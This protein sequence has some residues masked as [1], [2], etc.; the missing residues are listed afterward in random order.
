MLQFLRIRNLALLEAADLEFASGLVAVTGETGAGKSVLLGALSLLS[1]ARADKSLIRAGADTCTIEAGLW[2]AHPQEV[3]AAL[4]RLGLPLCEDGQLLLRRSFSRTRMGQIA[5]NGSLTTLANLQE[6]GEVW[7]D[8]HGPGEPQKLFQEKWQLSLLDA[9]ARL[10]P[11]LSAYRQA[12][13]R[14]QSL[15]R[16]AA[17]LRTQERLDDDAVE[18]L[19]RQIDAIDRAQLSEESIQILERDFTRFSRA[20]EIQE[21]ARRLEYALSGEEG[22]TDT[23]GPLLQTA[24]DLARLDPAGQDLA[25]RLETLI[26]EANDLASAYS[27]LA[28]ASHFDEDAATH[29][30]ERMQQWLELKRKHGGAVAQILAKRESLWNKLQMQSDVEGQLARLEAEADHLR[31]TLLD[32]AATLRAKRTTAAGELTR[33]AS[34]LLQRLGFKKA[35][36]TLEIVPEKD[37]RPHGDCACRFLFASHSGIDLQPLS[38][39][40]SSGEIARVMLALKAVLAR[41][42]RTPVLVFDEVDA[43]VG[44]EIARTVGQELA[45]LGAAHQVFCVTHL[46]QVAS[47]AGQHFLVSKQQWEDSTHIE[48]RRL[49]CDPQERISEL[50]RMLGDRHSASALAHARE[51]VGRSS[52]QSQISPSSPC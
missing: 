11:D 40:A 22:I 16:Q 49:D 51:L 18:F 30:Q 50:A 35:R 47:L 48:I 5:V 29:L 14:W 15:L 21:K 20:Q 7:I 28:A 38:K 32:Q 4:Q 13:D 39:I 12:Y 19:R 36:L 44:G 42:D 3:D 17:T 27:D 52:Q 8:F 6:L 25:A 23:L 33:Q 46:A 10:E 41:V 37:L 2:L 45:S 1:G 26:I 24:R 9:F 31:H 43:N 34:L